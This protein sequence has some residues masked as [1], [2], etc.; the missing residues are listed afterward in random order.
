MFIHSHG[1]LTTSI[2]IADDRT[3]VKLSYT[4]DEVGSDYINANYIH[5]SLLFAIFVIFQIHFI[6][7]KTMYI[8]NL[9][10]M[11]RI[12]LISHK[13]VGG[14]QDRLFRLHFHLEAAQIPIYKTK[15]TVRFPNI[16]LCHV[17][18]QP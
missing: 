17:L 8:E 13:V 2:F 1:V 18:L 5:V 16:D 7:P 6:K 14:R 4:D 15:L 3:R 9:W 10:L 12:E 11:Y